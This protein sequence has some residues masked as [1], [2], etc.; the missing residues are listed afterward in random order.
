MDDVLTCL[1]GV[2][3]TWIVARGTVG[4]GGEGGVA[5]GWSDA[6]RAARGGVPPALADRVAA[7]LPLASAASD[8][9]RFAHVFNAAR[10]GAAA[11]GAAAAARAVFSDWAHHV[12]RLDHARRAGTGGRAGLTLA[13]LALH[14]AGPVP[15]L[16]EAAA[17]ARAAARARAR[18]GAPWLICWPPA[19]PRP[20]ATHPAPQQR[21]ACWLGRRAPCLRH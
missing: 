19:P 4:E 18:R 8:V 20:R 13:G 14:V 15:A 21:D 17:A 16:L 11:Q 3:G 1:L 9:G 12:A 5:F 7:L 6:A 10:A 2:S